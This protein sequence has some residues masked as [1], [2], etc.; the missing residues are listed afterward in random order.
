M[1][2]DHTTQSSHRS[3]WLAEHIA[4][5]RWRYCSTY[6]ECILRQTNIRHG[7]IIGRLYVQLL[8]YCE[9]NKYCHVFVC[10]Y[11]RGLDWWM[12]LLNAYTHD[13]ELQALKR[14]RWSTHITNQ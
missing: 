5:L 7:S 9:V 14:Y 4:P 11:R 10:D 12:D 6:I 3:F 13:S 1:Q 8:W 2:W